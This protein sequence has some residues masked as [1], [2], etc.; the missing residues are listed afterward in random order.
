MARCNRQ[1]KYF[2]GLGPGQ[3]PEGN[4]GGQGLGEVF[5]ILGCRH[6]P[7]ARSWKGLR[8]VIPMRIKR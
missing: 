8:V 6:R 1:F 5:E 3:P 4:E 7:V 2:H